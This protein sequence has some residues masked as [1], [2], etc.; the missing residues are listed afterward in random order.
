METK[1]GKTPKNCWRAARAKAVFRWFPFIYLYHL[2][3]R[4][5][6]IRGFAAKPLDF[7]KKFPRNL[8]LDFLLLFVPA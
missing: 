4:S 8:S 2:E 3:T 1:K 5:I 6:K 7:L